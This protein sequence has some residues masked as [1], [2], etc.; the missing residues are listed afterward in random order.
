MGAVL[1]NELLARDFCIKIHRWGV[2]KFSRK[3]IAGSA[4]DTVPDEAAR[5]ASS[6]P[7]EVSHTTAQRFDAHQSCG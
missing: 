5:D 2:R 7:V 3:R 6:E 4:Y 1:Y